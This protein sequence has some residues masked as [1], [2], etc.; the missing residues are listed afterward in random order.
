MVL[1]LEGWA[2]LNYLAFALVCVALAVIGV[3]RLRNPAR[4]A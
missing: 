2:V 1:E 4:A 3:Y